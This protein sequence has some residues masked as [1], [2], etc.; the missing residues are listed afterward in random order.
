MRRPES[1]AALTRLKE[2]DEEA[3]A[4][5]RLREE[6]LNAARMRSTSTPAE[7]GPGQNQA[8][9]QDSEQEHSYPHN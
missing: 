3:L 4:D 9:G 6:L 7:R 8:A 1:D 5:A 2:D